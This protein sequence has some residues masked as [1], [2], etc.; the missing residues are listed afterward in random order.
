M[1]YSGP[2]MLMSEPISI[3][4]YVGSNN[5]KHVSKPKQTQHE[6]KQLAQTITAQEEKIERSKHMELSDATKDMC[7]A[8]PIRTYKMDYGDVAANLEHERGETWQQIQNLATTI[9]D[10]WL[11]MRDINDI[12]SPKE[13]KQGVQ[14]DTRKCLHLIT[15]LISVA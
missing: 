12:A 5:M 3:G 1:S 13:K 14:D 8:H 7:V 6:G 2:S 15:D 10:L 9:F 11:V 4:V